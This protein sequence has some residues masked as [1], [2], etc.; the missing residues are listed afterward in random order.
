VTRTAKVMEIIRQRIARRVLTSGARLPSIRGLA[1]DVAVSPSTVAEAY[2][3]LVAEGVI[4]SR[5]GSGFYVTGGLP[6]LELAEVEPR[7]EREIDPFWVSRQSLDAGTDMLRPGC[8]WLPPDWLPQKALRRGL[9]ALARTD[10]AV[11]TDYG[12]TRGSLA[13]R[14]ML[15]RQCAN[16]GIDVG[17]DQLLLTSTGTQAIDLVCRFLLQPGDTVL[18]DDPCYFNF[19]ALL[20]AHRVKIISAAYTPNGPDMDDFARVVE[21]RRP[22]LYITNSTLQN[23]TGATLSPAKAHAILTLAAAHG[24][25]IVEDEIF[26]DFE[27][28][29]TSRLAALDGLAT[30]IRIGSFSKVL[31]ASIRCGYVAAK[32]EWIE[33]LLDLQVA[34][35]FGGPSPLAAELVLTTLSDGSYRRHMAGLRTKLHRRRTEVADR[36]GAMEISPWVIPRGGFYLWCRLPRGI[37]AGDVARSAIHD[38]V[39]LAPGNVFSVAQTAS[40]FMRFNV[41]QMDQRAFEVLERSL[42]ATE[43]G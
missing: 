8:G 35:N 18:L 19:H 42:H 9:R 5:P 39:V 25:T 43:A 31:S 14:R 15:A 1:A 16:E 41:S 21:E 6:P 40:D 23:P 28:E 3:R 17:A 33:G 7:L 24:L 36:L 32:A 30:V 38:K 11:L 34:T 4:R 13:L 29:P 10:S 20:R 2:E 26:A 22:R 27:P 37:D 12:G